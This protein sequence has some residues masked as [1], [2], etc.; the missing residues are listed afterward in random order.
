VIRRSPTLCLALAT[1]TICPPTLA[2]ARKPTKRT[3]ESASAAA[4]CAKTRY[5]L[6]VHPSTIV[7]NERQRLLVRALAD[8]CGRQTAVRRAGVRLLGHRATTDSRGRCALDLRLPTGRYL[9]R[10]YVH[11]HPV[12]RTPVNA[13]PLV[14][15]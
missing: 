10:L 6:T 7:A 13:I 12:A 5:L 15:R 3:D 9:V 11:D 1:T 4:A 14:A 2:C 8:S